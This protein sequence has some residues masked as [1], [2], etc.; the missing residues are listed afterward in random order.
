M[1][2]EFGPQTTMR[3]E[4]LDMNDDTVQG[5]NWI[6]REM[7]FKRVVVQKLSPQSEMHYLYSGL[8]L[9]PIVCTSNQ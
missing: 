6:I 9:N 3:Q 7:S 4:R 2:V 1:Q 8:H 5:F